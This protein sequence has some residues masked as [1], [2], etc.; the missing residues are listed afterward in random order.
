M[1]RDLLKLFFI[2]IISPY[3]RNTLQ[4]LLFKPFDKMIPL[5]LV[6]D[7][8]TLSSSANQSV[9]LEVN[10]NLSTSVSLEAMFNILLQ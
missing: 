5:Q 10:V 3:E 8:Q 9:K 2:A 6:E 1:K 4:T 7:S